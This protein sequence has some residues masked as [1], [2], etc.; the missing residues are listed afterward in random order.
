MGNQDKHKTH[1]QRRASNGRNNPYPNVT[2]KCRD[3]S[4]GLVGVGKRYRALTRMEGKDRLRKGFTVTTLKGSCYPGRT[5]QQGWK[6]GSQ[7]R[8]L[9][10]VLNTYM[11]TQ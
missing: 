2:H 5:Q 11:K 9:K 7:T 1:S 8:Q 10:H 4:R 3:T 6:P